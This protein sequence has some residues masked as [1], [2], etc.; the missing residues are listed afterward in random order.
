MKQETKDTVLR[1]LPGYI[2]ETMARKGRPGLS[3]DGDKQET[4]LSNPI[5]W[6]RGFMYTNLTVQKNPN[7]GSVMVSLNEP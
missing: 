2:L 6:K 1:V 7:L 4:Q 3:P 5:S